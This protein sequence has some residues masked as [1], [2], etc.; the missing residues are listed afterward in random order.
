MALQQ[1][2]I[3]DGIFI[4]GRRKSHCTRCFNLCTDGASA[5]LGTWRAFVSK[6]GKLIRRWN[7]LIA[8]SIRKILLANKANLVHNLFLVYLFLVY[9]SISTCFGRLCAHHQKK[10]L[11]L[12]DSWYLL[13][14]LVPT[15][16]TRQSSTQNNKYQV[17]HKHSCF[18]WWW[19]HSRP[20]HVQI[21]KYTKNRLCTTLA[22]FTR[23]YRDTRSTKHR[24]ILCLISCGEGGYCGHSD[25]RGHQIVNL[26]EASW[27][28]NSCALHSYCISWGQ[29][30]LCN[31]VG[32][33]CVRA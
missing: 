11:C 32:T 19:A 5:M 9:L 16:H 28:H 17:A 33:F 6:G 23:L 7:L 2:K 8:S 15:L 20:K 14:C 31:E 3:K 13:L 18:S 21:D 4:C 10:Q 30:P 24:K 27:L 12:G 1:E 26:T 22:L 29:V 25:A